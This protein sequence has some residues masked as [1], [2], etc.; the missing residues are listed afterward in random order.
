MNTSGASATNRISAASKSGARAAGAERKFVSPFYATLIFSLFLPGV[1]LAGKVAGLH[2][3]FAPAMSATTHVPSV[4]LWAWERDEDLSFIDPSKV[5]VSYFAGMIYVRGAST[6]FRP[7]TQKLK[8]PAGV[9][10]VP[11]FRIET[12]RGEGLPGSVSTSDARPPEF[13]AADYIAKSIVKAIKSLPPSDTVQIDFDALA[14]ERPFYR[15]I[16]K[17]LRQELPPAR[18]IS[19]TALGSWLLSDKWLQDGDA[20]EVIAMMFSIGADRKNILQRVQSQRLD[21]GTNAQVSLGISANESL[22]NKA[23]FAA[24]LQNQFDKI[25]IFNSRPWNRDRF[26]AITKE[27]FQK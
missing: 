2:H 27:A 8:L 17:K 14:D 16:L 10:S 12:L 1:L 25:Y 11:V 4:N 7:R 6:E 22:T 20:D 3:I 5:G 24:H 18:R 26:D 9:H 13:A 15:T 21:S 23:L 19:I